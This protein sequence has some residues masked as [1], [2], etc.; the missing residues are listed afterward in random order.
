M[1]AS[2]FNFHFPSS[3]HTRT[4]KCIGRCLEPRPSVTIRGTHQEFFTVPLFFATKMDSKKLRRKNPFC[5]HITGFLEGEVAD[6]FSQQK[7]TSH[8]LKGKSLYRKVFHGNQQRILLV[9]PKSFRQVTIRNDWP[10][11]RIVT[12]ICL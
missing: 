2:H 1:V 11:R 7:S 9:V 3:V 6:Q 10:R 5:A 12:W 8:V 4:R